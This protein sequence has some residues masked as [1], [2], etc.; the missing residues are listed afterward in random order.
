V[1]LRPVVLG[2]IGRA[3]ALARRRL[4]WGAVALVLIAPVALW[5]LLRFDLD[6]PQPTLTALAK[7][8]ENRMQPG[9]RLAMV[10]PGD[11]DD[12]LGSFLRGHILFTRP[13]MAVP[14]FVTY[15]Q[16][17]PGTLA[18]AT[19]AG[20]DKLLLTCAPASITG[21]AEPA[22]A[23][24]GRDGGSWHLLA[25]WSYPARLRH[26]HFDS[27]IPRQGLCGG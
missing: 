26:E 9:D 17:Q 18:E 6:A 27:L 4:Q 3:S 24:M 5:P 13:R 21:T 11:T 2:W 15:P 22:A 8:V 23:L 16:F 14:A 12:A 1:W 19:K 7:G 10:L 25:A 20:F